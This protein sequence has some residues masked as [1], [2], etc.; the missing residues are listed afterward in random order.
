MS[1]TFI[2]VM[3]LVVLSASTVFAQGTGFHFQGRLND[4]TNPANG[5]YDL[6][7]GLFNAITG[8]TQIGATVARPNTVLINGVFS[9]TLDFGA[10]AFNNPN[11]VFI[12]ISVKPTGSPN[13][14]TILGPRQQLTVVPFAVRANT[15]TNADTAN[16]SLSLGGQPA[17]NYV[18]LF[19]TNAGF[20]NITGNI[21]STNIILAR[22]FIG[23]E[24]L[25][26]SGTITSAGNIYTNADLLADGNSSVIGNSTVGGS[27]TVAGT[28]L[29]PATTH[30]LPKAMIEAGFLGAGS[31]GIAKCFNG[32]TNTPL[33]Q[34]CGYTFS[35]PIIGVY[36]I[37]F[38][39]PISNL[40]VSATGRYASGSV[41][42]GLNN[43]S[44]SYRQFDNTTI[45]F[46]TWSPG[47]SADTITGAF[48]AILY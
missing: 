32:V 10:S 16:D 4:G 36:R 7:F 20:L 23:T 27:L 24:S 25:Q 28:A 26:T 22:T 15:A 29:Q 21:T 44:V 33:N 12:E 17:S 47:Q 38:G 31:L 46:Y 34:N 45:E 48:T 18:R 5:R 1:K 42:V 19:S 39:F 3:L 13:A 6:Q 11:S 30:G 9:T 14:F 35:N 43:F 2:K 8:G 41:G 37:N 40:F